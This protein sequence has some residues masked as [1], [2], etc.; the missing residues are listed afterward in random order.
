MAITYKDAILE[1]APSADTTIYTTPTVTSAHIIYGSVHNTTTSN[2]SIT[3]NI[4]QSGDSVATTNKYL[5]E[6]VPAGRSIKLTDI[7]NA[8]LNTGDIVNVNSSEANSLNVKL[9]I[10]EIT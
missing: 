10:K 3:V 7:I 2:V 6:T 9:G 4:V 1:P 8:V 5:S